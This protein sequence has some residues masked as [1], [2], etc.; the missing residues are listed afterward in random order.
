MLNPIWLK[1]FKTL[2]EVGHFTQTADTLF[3]T[4]PGVSQHIKKLEQACGHALIK[5]INKSFELT[6]QGKQ[7][8]HY[9][10]QSAEREQQLLHSLSE[11]SPYA[12]QCT[13]SCSGSFALWLYPQLL[14]LQH[15]HCDLSF[16]LEVAPNQ[17]ILDNI[18]NGFTDLGIVTDTAHSHLFSYQAVGEE[19]LCLVIGKQH[20]SKPVTTEL[21]KELGM[22]AHPDAKH[23]LAMYNER[24]H[25]P[26]LQGLEVEGI[27]VS[28]YINQLSQILLPVSQGIGFTVLPQSAIDAFP[29]KHQLVVHQPVS[30]VN[31]TLYLV[32][33][34]NRDLAK[35]YQTIQALITQREVTLQNQ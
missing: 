15:Q 29:D 3:M 5:R 21:L 34:K 30:A 8:Y 35:R 23:Y 1:T 22:I 20:K 13:I 2:V 6:E 17:R 32:H 19:P 10:L 25:S 12:G 24:C 27:K 33:K 11:D 14:T 9:A 16:Q 18:Q 7:V 26:E 31:E 4:Q 28:S